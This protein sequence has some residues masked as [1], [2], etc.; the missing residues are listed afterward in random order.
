MAQQGTQTQHLKP[1]ELLLGGMMQ[2]QNHLFWSLE[3]VKNVLDSY[4]TDELKSIHAA[5]VQ[6][7]S[8]RQIVQCCEAR[9]EH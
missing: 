8:H 3:P 6:L 9:C 2:N 5:K 7:N 1:D 4:H